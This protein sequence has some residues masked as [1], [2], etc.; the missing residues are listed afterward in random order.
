MLVSLVMAAPAEAEVLLKQ[1][2]EHGSSGGAPAVTPAKQL[3]PPQPGMS[4]MPADVSEM[5]G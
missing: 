4:D 2:E 3:L 1:A 5:V